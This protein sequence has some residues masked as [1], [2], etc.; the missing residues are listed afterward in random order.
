MKYFIRIKNNSESNI[1]IFISLVAIKK[2]EN[3]TKH[4]KTKYVENNFS[5]LLGISKTKYFPPTF[6]KSIIHPLN[7]LLL[8]IF[9]KKESI[10][11]LYDLYIF[12]FN[13]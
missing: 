4:L 6:I 5:I 8:P 7:N 2:I 10:L 3:N 9:N 1:D 11:L 13:F 12:F